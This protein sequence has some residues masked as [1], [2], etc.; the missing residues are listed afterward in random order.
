MANEL[1]ISASLNYNKV[2]VNEQINLTKQI[3][4]NLGC[5]TVATQTIGIVEE[6][7]AMVDVVDA[8]YIFVQNLDATNPVQVGT[9][10]GAYS[11]KLFPGDFALFPPNAT[12]LFLKSAVA[13]C[14]VAISV[15]NA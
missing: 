11:I 5:K 8:R 15:V 2:G 10:S 7:F 4:I 6:S 9:A 14:K 12:A 13:P 1:T 3:D